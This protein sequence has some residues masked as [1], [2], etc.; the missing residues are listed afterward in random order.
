MVTES[1]G[2]LEFHRTMWKPVYWEEKRDTFSRP[3]RG[4]KVAGSRQALTGKFQKAFPCHEFSN[5][6]SY[7][8]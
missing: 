3:E 8:S 5:T 6:G 1:E 2:E 4:Q 7:S